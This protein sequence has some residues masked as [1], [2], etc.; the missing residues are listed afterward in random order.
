MKTLIKRSTSLVLSVILW[1]C[2][3]NNTSTTAE[4]EAKIDPLDTKA[5]MAKAPTTEEVN[6]KIPELKQLD[7]MYARQIDSAVLSFG[8][9]KYN[10]LLPELNKL[11]NAFQ[12]NPCSETKNAVIAYLK[13][14]QL[15]DI[16]TKPVDKTLYDKGLKNYVII[17]ERTAMESDYDKIDKYY[18]RK[19]E[20][21]SRRAEK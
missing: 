1:S 13:E 12:N 19:I 10:T 15:F 17:T 2:A 11:K 6:S 20:L 18:A 16:I 8:P 7:D 9:Q 4:G 21:A 3:G 14:Y 5:L